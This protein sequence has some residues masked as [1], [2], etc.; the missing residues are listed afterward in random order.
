MTAPTSTDDNAA[1]FYVVEAYKT[2]SALNAVLFTAFLSANGYAFAGDHEA[3]VFFV[4]GAL[5]PVL[6]FAA[7]LITKY[8]YLSP[9]LYKALEFEFRKGDALE[10]LP[11]LFISFGKGQASRYARLF[12]ELEPSV[13]RQRK[14]RRIYVFR[15]ILFKLSFFSSFSIVDLNS[16]GWSAKR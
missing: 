5:V 14:F 6:A 4:L 10:S 12:L 9:L 1:F 13:T 11:F 2:R 7:D 15:N 8:S 3:R 16:A